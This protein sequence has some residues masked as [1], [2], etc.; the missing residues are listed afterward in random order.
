MALETLAY[1]HNGTIVQ[2]MGERVAHVTSELPSKDRH[3]EF[4]L[5]L[6]EYD[7][8]ILQ[9]VGRS[10]VP[11]ESD[12]YWAVISDD[13]ADILQSIVGNEVS[14]LAKRLL[15]EAMKHLGDCVCD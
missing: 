10:R 12:R 15:T 1:Q 5:F 8:W 3:T 4:S 11:G 13:P 6:S 14:R 9:G 2:F 7:E